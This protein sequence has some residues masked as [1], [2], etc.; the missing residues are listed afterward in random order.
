MN[1]KT[2]AIAAAVAIAA[3][4]IIRKVPAINKYLNL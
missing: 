3:I 2:I 1:V 4:V